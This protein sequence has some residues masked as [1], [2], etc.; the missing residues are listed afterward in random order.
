[1]NPEE[2]N[3]AYVWDMYTE[4]KQI[5]EFTSDV[6]FTDFVKIKLIRYAIE[7][8]LLILGE[9]ANHVTN[10]FQ[11][12]HPEIPWHQIIGQR[13]VLAHEYGD[14]NVDRI[15]ATITNNIPQ[16]L[17]NLEKLLEKLA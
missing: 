4:T 8:S 12:E 6:T 16:L 11:E 13:N 15:W 9:A 1:M 5:I 10:Q 7:R 2:K 3:L 14:I 17:I